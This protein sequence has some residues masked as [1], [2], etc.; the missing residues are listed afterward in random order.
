MET[1]INAL[2]DARIEI[3]FRINQLATSSEPKYDEL[4]DLKSLDGKLEQVIEKYKHHA[5]N[6]RA[7]WVTPKETAQCETTEGEE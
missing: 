4:N 1:L 2:K 6:G 7:E 5:Y 3:L